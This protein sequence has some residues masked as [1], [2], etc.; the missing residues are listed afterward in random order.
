MKPARPG[1]RLLSAH[2]QWAPAVE[3][4]A[5][6]MGGGTRV[7]KGKGEPEEAG[8]LAGLAE[9]AEDP[10]RE[11]TPAT[12]YKNIVTVA[13]GQGK[14]WNGDLANSSDGQSVRCVWVIMEA[15]CHTWTLC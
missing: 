12:F 11:G 8:G 10:G 14:E 3:R 15:A 13:S 9:K 2:S 1:T 4:F 7:G 6:K 5:R